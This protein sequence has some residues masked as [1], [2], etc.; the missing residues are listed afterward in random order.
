MRYAIL[1]TFCSCT[2]HESKIGV[3]SRALTLA[4]RAH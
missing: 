4:G 2:L 1:N 3:I